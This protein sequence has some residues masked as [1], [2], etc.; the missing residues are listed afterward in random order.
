M[1]ELLEVI[2]GAIFELLLEA[3]LELIAAA[4]LGLAT[5]AL[6]GVFTG[7]A[8]AIKKGN[9]VLTSIMYALLGVL[10]GALSLLVLPH[11]LIHRQHPTPFHGISLVISPL[12]SGV[13]LSLVGNILRRLGKRVTP[14]ETF[15]YQLRGNASSS[16]FDRIFGLG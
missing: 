9:R 13:V 7:I 3:F 12:V 4:V 2:L 14:L 8:E 15:G 5:R 11:P 16:F 1:E 10:A 6:L